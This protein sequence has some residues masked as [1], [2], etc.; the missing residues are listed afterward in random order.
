[1]TTRP[2]CTRR[3]SSRIAL[4]E[5]V[6][7]LNELNQNKMLSIG[8]G[9]ASNLLHEFWDKGYKRMPPK[10]RAT[11]YAGLFGA[12]SGDAAPA[13]PNSEFPELCEALLSA[14]ADASGDAVA[15]AAAAVR[16]NIG[17]QLGEATVK[18]AAEMRG[19]LAELATVLSDMELR[20]AYRADDMWHVV[21]RVQEEFGG[22]P[23]VQGVRARALS[24]A[25]VLHELPALADGVQPGDEVV[26]AARAWLAAHAG[27]AA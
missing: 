25:R 11:L 18:A 12:P 3:P 9:Q 7:R 21:M 1:M 5:L 13:E 26:D 10:R 6:E 27:D 24:G 14:I 23:D 19:T 8:A 15:P 22:G 4:I 20:N 17:A 16:D 2:C